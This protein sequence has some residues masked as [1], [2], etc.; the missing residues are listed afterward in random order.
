[1]VSHV[2]P[3]KE[4]PENNL[5]PRRKAIFRPVLVIFRNIGVV[6]SLPRCTDLL[7]LVG[8]QLV[9]LCEEV[10]VNVVCKTWCIKVTKANENAHKPRKW[11]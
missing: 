11:T 2:V 5:V 6:Y 1:M 10:C 7:K 4:C 9:K 8:A 3:K